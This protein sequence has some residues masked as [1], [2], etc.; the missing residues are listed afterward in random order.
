MK[1]PTA[2]IVEDDMLLARHIARQLEKSGMTAHHATDALQAIDQIDKHKPAVIFLDLLLTG[3][4]GFVL[5]NELQSHADLATIPVVACSNLAGDISLDSLR[6]Y[7]VF[8]LLDKATMLPSD[9]VSAA[10]SQLS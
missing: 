2:I 3:S 9:I 6:P 4:T 10:W 1:K 8:A 7:G 5:L